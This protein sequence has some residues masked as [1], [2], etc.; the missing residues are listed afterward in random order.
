M[1]HKEARGAAGARR[2]LR[3]MPRPG[4]TVVVPRESGPHQVNQ[5]PGCLDPAPDAAL[6]VGGTVGRTASNRAARAWQARTAG[7]RSPGPAAM[8]SAGRRSRGRPGPI[9]SGGPTPLAMAP[10]ARALVVISRLASAPRRRGS[11]APPARHAFVA[12]AV[13]RS[14]RRRRREPAPPPGPHQVSVAVLE[15]TTSSASARVWQCHVRGDRW[16]RQPADR[17]RSM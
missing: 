1:Y 15:A 8:S 11:P 17:V 16:L 9:A 13:A 7:R 6:S 5:Q 12:E 2:G 3:R 14:R 10:R 4:P